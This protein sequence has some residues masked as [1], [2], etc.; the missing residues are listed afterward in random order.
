MYL[1]E[2]KNWFWNFVLML[3]GQFFYPLA[4]AHWMGLYKSSAWYSDYRYWMVAV[5]FCLFPV[6][7]LFGILAIQMTCTVARALN[8]PG[9]EIYGYPY[10]WIVCFIVPIIGWTL[11]WVLLIYLEVWIVVMLQKGEG[12]KFITK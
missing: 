8:V 7:I 12:E 11:F 6:S 9:K 10:A 5:L 2:R 4:L 1:L 3:A